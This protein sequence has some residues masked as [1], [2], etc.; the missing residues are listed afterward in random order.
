MTNPSVLLTEGKLIVWFLSTLWLPM[1]SLP[2]FPFSDS[3]QQFPSILPTLPPFFS[4]PAECMPPAL[5]HTILR[6][7]LLPC[8]HCGALISQF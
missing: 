8:C 3:K 6:G 2:P 5:E 1:S 7:F 4:P